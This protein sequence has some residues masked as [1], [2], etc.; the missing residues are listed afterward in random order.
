MHSLG[1]TNVRQLFSFLKSE[2]PLTQTNEQS[3]QARWIEDDTRN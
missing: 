2:T 1:F 3:L